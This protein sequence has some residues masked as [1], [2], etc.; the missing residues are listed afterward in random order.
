MTNQIQA[1]EH[2]T[3]PVRT[4]DGVAGVRRGG[5][6]GLAGVAALFGAFLPYPIFGLPNPDDVESLTT[7]AD[8]T[9]GR[10]I[11][12][13]F[14]LAA[15]VLWAVH[16]MAIGRA[17]RNRSDEE[18]SFLPAVAVFGLAPMAAG[19]LIHV[20]TM[21]LSDLY[22]DP[23]TTAAD[24]ANIVLTWQAV[25]A[26]F[27][28]LLVTGAAIVPVAMVAI[29]WSL[30]S[31]GLLGRLSGGIALAISVLG[32]VGGAIAIVAGAN[33]A[34]VQLAVLSMLVFHAVVGWRLF[35]GA[36]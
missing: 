12:N 23:A 27:N 15:L 11:E 25:Q 20:A 28:T 34:G 21:E 6:A 1:T 35:R 26:V 13:T 19:A 14:W 8:I 32:V 18:R 10:I 33:S 24:Q 31:A 2:P 16:F 29:A 30:L 7:F 17:L 3:E 22:T 36:F 4:A 9:T 5:L